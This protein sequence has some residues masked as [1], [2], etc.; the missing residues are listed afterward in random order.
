MQVGEV[1]EVCRGL[2]ARELGRVGR[3]L[4]CDEVRR[5]ENE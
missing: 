3:E 5:D 1:G 4:A 2:G